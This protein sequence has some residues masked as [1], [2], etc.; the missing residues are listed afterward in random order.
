MKSYRTD[1]KENEIISLVEYISKYNKTYIL[2]GELAILLNLSFL[3]TTEL[4][5]GALEKGYFRAA[6]K[7]ELTQIGK[8]HDVEIYYL[9]DKWEEIMQQYNTFIRNRIE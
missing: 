4:I 1:F 7:E 5:N 9:G 6:S 8:R 2:T 3:S